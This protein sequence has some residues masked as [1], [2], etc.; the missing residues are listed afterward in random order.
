VA[1]TPP[2]RPALSVDKRRRVE[3]ALSELLE[4]KRLL[5]QVR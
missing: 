2:P 5:E 4:A 3:A 1:A